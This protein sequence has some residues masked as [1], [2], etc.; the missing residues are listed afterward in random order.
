MHLSD[1]GYHGETHFPNGLIPARV[2]SVHKNRFN[3]VCEYGEGGATLKG[4]P[5]Y[6]SNESF[7]TTGDFVLIAHQQAGDSLIIKTLPRTTF[8]TRADPNS[9]FPKEQA[10]AANFDTVFILQSLNHDFSLRRLERYLTLAKK[11]RAAS[12]VIYTK[13]D[14]VMDP[15]PIIQQAQAVAHDVPVLALSAATGQGLEALAPYLT[16]G[17]TVVFLGSSGVG[18][19]SLINRI[20]GKELMR[21][22]AVRQG[23]DKGRHT[24]THRELIRLDT[25][26]MLIDT[27]GMRALGMLGIKEG[28]S[29]T[30]EDVE[31]LQGQCRF[32]NCRHQSEPGCAIQ[33]AL[34]SGALQ[35]ER[36]DSYQRLRR[37]DSFYDKKEACRQSRAEKFKA[38]SKANHKAGKNEQLF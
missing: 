12:V 26:V 7:P 31:A 17:Q 3:I 11:S 4:T 6:L 10:V 24:T 8:F 38:I 16:P 25:G 13:S 34:A 5:Y 35:K 20:A 32:S 29:Q 21:T 18:K 15:T 27:P 36:W 23:D 14:L 22:H 19:S 30:F 37:E 9:V 1:Y 33:A 2:T 28:L